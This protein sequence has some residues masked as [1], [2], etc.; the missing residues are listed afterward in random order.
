MTNGE[1]KKSYYGLKAFLIL[2]GINRKERAKTMKIS[3][4]TLN[5]KLNGYSDFTFD[6][7]MIFCNK[8]NSCSDLFSKS[9][10]FKITKIKE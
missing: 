5:N 10:K 8:Y 2:N 3:T 9:S 6:E 1:V 4:R 7:V